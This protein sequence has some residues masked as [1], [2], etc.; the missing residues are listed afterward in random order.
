MSLLVAN[1]TQTLLFQTERARQEAYLSTALNRSSVL[2][3]AADIGLSAVKPTPATGKVLCVSSESE[4]ILLPVDTEFEDNDGRVYRTIDNNTIAANSSVVIDVEQ[5]EK[6]TKTFISNG[7]VFQEYVFGDADVCRFEVRV[8]DEFWTQTDSFL[9]HKEDDKVYTEMLTETEQMLIRFSTG[10]FGAIPSDGDEIEVTIYKT[11]G[12]DVILTA[13]NALYLKTAIENSNN[14]LIA[15][16][17]E[18]NT[19]ISGGISYP[20]TDDLR[21][22]VLAR[23]NY[24]E[25]LVWA[26]DY[27]YFIQKNI[28]NVN[29]V[30]VWGEAEQEIVTGIDIDN[31]NKVFISAYSSVATDPTLFADSVMSA[32][33][34][35]PTPINVKHVFVSPTINEIYLK[36]T[37]KIERQHDVSVVRDAINSSVLSVYGRSASAIQP[38]FRVQDVQSLLYALGYFTATYTRMLIGTSQ[39]YLSIDVVSGKTGEMG[40]SEI[41][42]VVA[43]E[44]DVAFLSQN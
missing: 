42:I 31:T 5:T 36:I 19:S 7:T 40:L 22:D 12:S 43:I 2:A 29:W 26:S 39:P 16:E 17:F 14:E 44:T 27:E 8:N 24:S 1:A 21:N 11:L 9:F 15:I 18:T 37:A 33:A 23:I 4:D 38:V 6:T 10:R 25:R 3:H 30:N 13:A 20:S 34:S 32:I 41:P 35:A 28:A